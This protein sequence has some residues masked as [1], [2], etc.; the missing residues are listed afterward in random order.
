ML[1]KALEYLRKGIAVI[2]IKKGDKT[3]LLPS[4]KEFETRKP[5]VEEVTRWW[6]EYPDANI[7]LLTGKISGITVI[8]FD[9]KKDKLTGKPIIGADGKLVYPDKIKDF[10]FD[11]LIVKSGGGGYHYYYR[12][13]EE[14]PTRNDF[15]GGGSHVDV[16]NDG[17]YII[18]PPSIHPSGNKYEV[19][20]DMVLREVDLS[21]FPGLEK[22]LSLGERIAVPA[23]N[24]N[25]S[26]ASFAGTLLHAFAPIE[27]E[28][29]VYPAMEQVNKTYDPP[30]NEFEL[31][32]VYRSIA[33]IELARRKK[34]SAALM[35]AP[36]ETKTDDEIEVV[37]VQE[38]GEKDTS[39][40]VYF[41][42]GI[43]EFDKALGGG[44][45]DGD[46]T[47]ISG[48]TGQGKTLLSQTINYNLY[49]AGVSCIWFEYEVTHRELWE[50]FKKMGIEKDFPSY[51]PEK[52]V[53]ADVK[54]IEKM[55]LKSIAKYNVK[56][57][58]IDHLTNLLRDSKN[59]ELDKNLSNNT[60]LLLGAICRGLKSI[61]LKH[62]VSIVLMAHTIKP[63]RGGSDMSANDIGF[64]GGIAQ[65]SDTVLMI[66]RKDSQTQH[67]VVFS[68]D[69]EVK[70]EKNR[71]TGMTK[72]IIMTFAGGRL[73]E[74][75]EA[76]D[77]TFGKSATQVQEAKAEDDWKNL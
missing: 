30:L 42:T 44:I 35:L 37:T 7:A 18:M 8:D 46:L 25:N 26:M 16:K 43:E 68:Q 64:S 63:P 77:A 17:G 62:K 57:V 72:K 19:F 11:T 41:P 49:K 55:I 73:Q 21:K 10:P 51:T 2:P 34:E 52:N 66:R 59:L 22:K 69:S 23:G 4:W 29:Q 14:L 36:N 20:L 75:N 70:L 58:F 76:I 24:R 56:V 1:E 28:F 65:E 60:S 50:K 61:A 39:Q 27:W 74:K 5:T 71:K 48:W 13:C 32:S 47:T 45:Q 54:W 31:K 3:P 15:F 53:S 40:G 38:A 67:D 12:Y 9:V 33:N 6:T